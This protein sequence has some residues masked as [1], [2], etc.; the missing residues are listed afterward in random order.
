M[1]PLWCLLCRLW[2]AFTQDCSLGAQLAAGPKLMIGA[3]PDC[4]I[5]TALVPVSPPKMKHRTGSG[6]VEVR[7]SGCG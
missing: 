6:S 3:P 2:A 1:N 4:G 5:G 7:S